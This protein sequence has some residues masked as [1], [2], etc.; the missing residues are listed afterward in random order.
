[1]VVSLFLREVEFSDRF[2]S[3]RNFGLADPEVALRYRLSSPESRTVWSIQGLVKLP[4]DTSSATPPLGNEQTD[5]EG[6]LLVGRGFSVGYRGAFWNVE[7]AYRFRDEAPADEFRLD[8]TLGFDLTPDWLVMGQ[9]FGIK[10]LE[11]GSPISRPGNPTLE[12]D[13]DL[14]KMQ[15]SVVWRIAPSVRFQVGYVRDLAGRNTGAGHGAI[16]ALWLKF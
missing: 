14:Y 12:T 8:A 6:R 3:D 13:Y 1:M 2:G 16:F 4:V 15:L 5:V 9:F 7:G 11:N 10:G